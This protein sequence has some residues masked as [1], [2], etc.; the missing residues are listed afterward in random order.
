MLERKLCD[1][2][3]LWCM[4]SKPVAGIKKMWMSTKIC[5]FEAKTGGYNPVPSGKLT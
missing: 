2:E 3:L 4:M 5:D 1:G